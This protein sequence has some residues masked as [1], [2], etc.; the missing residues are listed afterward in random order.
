M[1]LHRIVVL[2]N[3]SGQKENI[4]RSAASNIEKYLSEKN[5]Q[6]AVTSTPT[7]LF[8]KCVNDPNRPRVVIHTIQD[9]NTCDEVDD[10]INRVNHITK[11]RYNPIAV[12]VISDNRD[13]KDV[14]GV[15]FNTKTHENINRFHLN[16]WFYKT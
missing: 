16:R 5:I 3:I 12:Q 11:N 2:H 14:I 10:I 4:L 7:E 13:D 6:S 1:L 8:D 15:F 9:A